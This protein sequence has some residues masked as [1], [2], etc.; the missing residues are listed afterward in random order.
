MLKRDP[1]LQD[2][3][4]EE[5]VDMPQPRPSFKHVDSQVIRHRVNAPI[6]KQPQQDASDSRSD[7]GDGLMFE[8]QGSLDSQ[9]KRAFAISF[10]GLQM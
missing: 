2:N 9:S 6:E 1:S 8:S 7:S 10:A 5:E 4:D 3:E